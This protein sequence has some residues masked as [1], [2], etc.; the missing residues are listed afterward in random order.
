MWEYNGKGRAK[1]LIAHRKKGSNK[2][3]AGGK[4]VKTRDL[5]WVF[6][7]GKGEKGGV[8]A[9]LCKR[10][11]RPGEQGGKNE[12]RRSKRVALRRQ[13]ALT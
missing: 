3:P 13:A 12:G 6:P 9:S 11:R 4:D 5:D 8:S 10:D 1:I 2:K 7:K